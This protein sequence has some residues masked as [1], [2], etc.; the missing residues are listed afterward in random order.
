MIDDLNSLLVK[1]GDPIRA[2]DHN[3]LVAAIRRRKII[4][5][6]GVRVCRKDNGTTITYVAQNAISVT[7]PWRLSKTTTSTG[8]EALRFTKGL[9]NGYEPQIDGNDISDPASA[10]LEIPGYDKDLG[11]CLVYLQLSLDIRSWAISDVTVI[12]SATKPDFKPFTAL[13]LI[14]LVN[15]KSGIVPEASPVHNLGFASSNHKGSGL[16]TPWWWAMQ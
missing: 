16:F 6:P 2:A 15:Q 5:G 11:D 8:K 9:V 10:P 3:G 4:G 13:K 1:Q 14:G 12:A 7:P